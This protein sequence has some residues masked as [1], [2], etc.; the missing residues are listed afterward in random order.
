MLLGLEVTA[1]CVSCLLFVAQANTK[2]HA[3]SWPSKQSKHHDWSALHES[4][5]GLIK[6]PSELMVFFL[7]VWSGSFFFNA[8]VAYISCQ[9]VEQTLNI[10]Q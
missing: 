8:S 9:G 10:V 3:A 6:S 5:I 4:N 1:A 2:P 7:F